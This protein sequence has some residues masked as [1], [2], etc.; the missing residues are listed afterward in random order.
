M[1]SLAWPDDCL[2]CSFA[3]FPFF[4]ISC[5]QSIHSRA[6]APPTAHKIL[7]HLTPVPTSL[8]SSMLSFHIPGNYF[9]RW[10]K[11]VWTSSRGISKISPGSKRR[12]RI[13]FQALKWGN[14]WQ[15][16]KLHCGLHHDHHLPAGNPRWRLTALRMK[17]KLQ[18][19]PEGT[20]LC[21]PFQS[22]L[23]PLCFQNMF[24]NHVPSINHGFWEGSQEKCFL[25]INFHR[26]LTIIFSS[27][28][29]TTQLP[30][31]A[32]LRL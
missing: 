22:H 31:K 30:E 8:F 10:K 19:G 23:L 28:E 9:L 3:F 17:C 13:L 15:T 14:L 24:P 2:Y 11:E 4:K 20:V 1:N 32:P 6:A 27:F 5:G 18:A 16:G 21:S 12:K 7:K 25:F 26:N 29:I